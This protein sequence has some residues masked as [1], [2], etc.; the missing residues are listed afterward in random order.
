MHNICTY[1]KSLL[2]RVFFNFPIVL[3]DPDGSLGPNGPEYDY[4][5]GGEGEDGY[6]P[7][8]LTVQEFCHFRPDLCVVDEK[9]EVI[10]VHEL[11]TGICY[12]QE[13]SDNK[14]GA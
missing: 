14:K 3:L 5:T 12:F 10:W 4:G 7:Q 13:V 1:K 6:D 9:Q 2:F 11:R 8:P